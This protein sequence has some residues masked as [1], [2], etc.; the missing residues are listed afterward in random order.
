M[1]VGVEVGAIYLGDDA[2]HA[3]VEHG[4]QLLD[5]PLG[6]HLARVKVSSQG[7]WVRVGVGG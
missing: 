6:I 2:L 7:K 5:D 1:R 3:A 4:L